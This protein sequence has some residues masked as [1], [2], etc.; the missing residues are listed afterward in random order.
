[1]FLASWQ[2]NCDSITSALTHMLNNEI[3][4]D[5]IFK[6]D[7]VS[8]FFAHKLVLAIWSP[9]FADWIAETGT[10]QMF[11]ITFEEDEDV[12]KMILR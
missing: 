5:A 4:V 10:K 7:K 8:C 12:L 1:M 11:S 9:K 6:K 3:I 2:D